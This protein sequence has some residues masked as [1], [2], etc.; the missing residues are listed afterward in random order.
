[1]KLSSRP[2]GLAITQLTF[3][4]YTAA[5]MTNGLH[6]TGAAVSTYHQVDL[7]ARHVH[8]MAER[9]MGDQSPS[10]ACA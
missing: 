1:M 4:S 9:Q 7:L 8:N 5:V 10:L 3:A 6:D 2:D